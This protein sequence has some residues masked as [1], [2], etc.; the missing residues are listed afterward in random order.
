MGYNIRRTN[1]NSLE[2]FI[3]WHIEKQKTD[4]N[5]YSSIEIEKI[6]SLIKI[7]FYNKKQ[8]KWQLKKVYG[9]IPFIE[10]SAKEVILFLN[11]FFNYYYFELKDKKGKKGVLDFLKTLENRDLKEI[12]SNISNGFKFKEGEVPLEFVQEMKVLKE[13][14][15]CISHNNFV[16][17]ISKNF[18]TNYTKQTLRRYYFNNQK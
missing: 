3:A 4:F 10:M 8:Y 11:S 16:K 1:F 2:N 13:K 17:F 7:E 18:N 15:L 12:E 9:F 14:Y 6:N 5:Q